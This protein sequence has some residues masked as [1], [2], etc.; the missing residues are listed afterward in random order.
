LFGVGWMPYWYAVLNDQPVLLP[1]NP[2][3][4]AAPQ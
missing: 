4:G 1:A 2:V 3:A